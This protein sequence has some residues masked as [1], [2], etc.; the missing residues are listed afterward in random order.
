MGVM[1]IHRLLL[2]MSGPMMLS[3]L[4]QALYNVVDSMFVSYINESALTAVSLAYPVQNL[5]IAVATGTGVGSFCK[6]KD[7]LLR[8]GPA[9]SGIICLIY[10]AAGRQKTMGQQAVVGNQKQPFRILVKPPHRK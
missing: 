8:D 6:C 5:M 9:D 10:V 4:I 7:V 2:T 3:M 1:P